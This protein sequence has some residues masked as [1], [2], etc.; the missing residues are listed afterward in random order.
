MKEDI[1]SVE[2]APGKVIT[3]DIGR[4]AK[5]AH[6]SVVVGMGETMVLATAV[7]AYEAKEGQSFF[8]LTVDYR[9]NFYAAG[10][11]P[12]GF[13]KREGKATEKEI[14]TSRLIDRTIRP[15]FAEGYLNDTQ[16]LC[17]VIS[18][19]KENDGDVLSGVASSI[20]LTISDIPFDGPT[21]EV[22]VGRINGE[23]VINPTISEMKLSDLE[24]VI[25]GTRESVAMVEG[26][27]KEIS[28]AEMLAAIK[29]GHDAIIR[30]C[31]WQLELQ[32]EF[33][34]EKR[35]L[36]EAVVNTELKAKVVELV[37]TKIDEITHSRP[38]KKEYSDAISAVVS[39]VVA[40]LEEAY[41]DE[42]ATIKEFC[43][44]IQ[45]KAFRSMIVNDKIRLDG[46]ALDQVRPI[47]TQV[48]YIPRTHGS[49]IFTRG[50]TQSLATVTLGTKRDAQSVDTLFSTE[51]KSFMLDYNFP[52][53]STGEAKPM[54][55]PGRREIGHGNLAERALKMMM[56]SDAEFNYTVRVVS[57]ILESNGSSSMASV[58]GGSMA[59]M[60]AGVPVKKPVS[61][62][63]M[64]MIVDGEKVAV[65]TDIQGEEDHLGD[66]DF[67]LAGTS[68]GL[69][70][71]QMDI[72][73]KGI[74]Y[75]VMER[76]M[77]QAR[78]GRLHILGKMAET[79]SVSRS[80]VS[81]YAPT[82]TTIE[83]PNDQIGAV[84]G[85]GGKVIQALQKE[86]NTEIVIEEQGN[87]G[88]VSIAAMNGEDAE[89][90]IKRIK[91]ITGSFEEGEVFEG[92]VKSIKEFGAFVEIAPGKDGLL[93]I[94]EIDHRRIANVRDVLQEGDKITVKL[95]KV[96]HGG[97]L[98]L[99]RKALIERPPRE[100]DAP[101]A[102]QSEEPQA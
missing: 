87:K 68:D 62:V 25:G 36:V 7:S 101:Q 79:I 38:A 26:E 4:L 72:K 88:L 1:R 23:L 16:V 83:I 37:G 20:A 98:K 57:D 17:Y 97:K 35:A 10:R 59:L 76:A 30:L 56:P 77:E 50:E 52:P 32:K 81:K 85:P 82:I 3:A 27:M 9:E 2:F 29:F 86:T 14:L 90:A 84:I 75:D 11:F 46:R 24:L 65:L 49:A 28:E 55:G 67:K 47:W 54:R 43:Y 78:Q 69:T 45:K 61:G 21:A 94:S 51:S 60:D 91:Q 73:V 64:G 12:G 18:S 99:S 58:C 8:P 39:D 93:H 74:P 71:C 53:Y 100:G 22:R 102:H 15:M 33:G 40:Q 92:V 41:P 5:Q 66:M 19:D 48:G 63:A 42:K 80:K 6:G 13:F 70:A 44:E 96:E 95:L 34:K 89:M 31:D